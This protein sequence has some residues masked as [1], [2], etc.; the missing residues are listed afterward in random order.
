M[1]IGSKIRVSDNSGVCFIRVIK[2]MKSTP[3]A[4]AK[5]GSIIYGSI[6]RTHERQKYPFTK[7]KITRVLAIR[8]ARPFSRTTGERLKFQESVV[9]T[10]TR[11]KTPKGTRIFGP[12]PK[13]LREYGFIRLICICP[14]V[15]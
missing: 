4:F 6:L 5:I 1:K 11:K 13:E 7:G 15:I 14:K 12:V 9:A 3:R 10:I 8:I 2:I